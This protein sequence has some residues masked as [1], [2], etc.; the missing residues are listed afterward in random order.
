M[1]ELKLIKV[2]EQAS[3]DLARTINTMF[4]NCNIDRMNDVKRNTLKYYQKD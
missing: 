4:N 3:K 1:N 2:N